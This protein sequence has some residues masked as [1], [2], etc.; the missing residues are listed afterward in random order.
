MTP[1][2]IPATVRNAAALMRGGMFGR[3]TPDAWDLAGDRNKPA[4]VAVMA[5]LVGRKLPV[6]K[7]GVNAIEAE[8]LR[9]TGCATRFALRDLLASLQSGIA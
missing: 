6:A 9:Q 5:A 1:E 4:R 2:T 7:C 8:L 3:I